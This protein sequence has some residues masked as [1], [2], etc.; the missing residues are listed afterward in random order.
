MKCIRMN[1][2]F[3]R[4]FINIYKVNLT[5]TKHSIRFQ[6]KV[7]LIPLFEAIYRWVDWFRVGTI[8]CPMNCFRLSNLRQRRKC[9]IERK[10]IFGWHNV[11]TVCWVW[12]EFYRVEFFDLSLGS[13]GGVRF[14]VVFLQK[15]SLSID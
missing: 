9:A 11:Q 12:K 8:L 1:Q 4:F 14:G 6:S 15:N 2:K 3:V 7:Q 5:K 10:K 13:S